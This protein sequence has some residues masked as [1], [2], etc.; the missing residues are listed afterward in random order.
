MSH[1]SKF[2][3]CCCCIS[4]EIGTR[5]IG[6]VFLLI[7]L[8][9]FI[10]YLIKLEDAR[11]IFLH[12][13]Y[14]IQGCT[15]PPIDTLTDSTFEYSIL[16]NL[17]LIIG[18]VSCTRWLL[19]PWLSVYILNM[20]LLICVSLGMFLSPIPLLHGDMNGSAVHQSLRLLGFIPLLLAAAIFYA[21]LVV[22]SRFIE[23]G[24]LEK[25]ED[26]QCCPMELKKGVQILGGILAILSGVMLVVFFAKLDEIIS[27]Q[28]YKIFEVEIS[29]KT[30][31]M[32]GGSIVLSIFVNILM[33]LGCSG[34]KWRRVMVLPWLLFYGAGIVCC[35]WT[36]LYYTS[37]C[38]REEKMIGLGCLGLG[39]VFLIIWSM[40]WM[41][42]AQVT[43][44][45]KTLISTPNPLLFKRA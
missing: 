20:F 43:E 9:L 32:M 18:C 30:L 21:W 29:R 39:F 34:R 19:V 45:Q 42:A 31:T 1:W 13:L 10:A 16:A 35:I 38:W 36:H 27:Q 23:L 15:I 33:I 3:K 25:S 2:E 12:G 40:V 4:L 11:D 26:D 22:R 41:V 17:L 28:Y 6:A 8:A 14:N 5:L 37:K 44:K 24:K 7:S